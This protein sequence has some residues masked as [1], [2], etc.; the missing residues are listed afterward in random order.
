MAQ[1]PAESR[2]NVVPMWW[3]LGFG[4]LTTVGLAVFTYG[5][6]LFDA[7]VYGTTKVIAPETGLAPPNND[8]YGLAFAVAVIVN[9]VSGPV[10]I[11]LATRTRARTWRPVA[12]GLCAALV[13]AMAA[14][15][16]LLLTLGINPVEFVLAF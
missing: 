11:W 13:A 8:R 3:T 2:R 14:T 1:V 7:L 16:A 6:L 5:L 15:C 9:L 4:A 12:L 10:L